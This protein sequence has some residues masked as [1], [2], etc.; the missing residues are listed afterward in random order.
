MENVRV[1]FAPSPTGFLH[2]GGARTALFNWLFAKHEGGKFILRIEDT[3]TERSTSEYKMNILEDLRWLGLDWDEGPEVEGRF[4]PYLQSQRFSIYQSYIQRLLDSGQAYY[5]FCSMQELEKERFESEKKK[6]PYHYSKKCRTLSQ[7]E[8]E[9]QMKNNVAFSIRIKVPNEGQLVIQDMIRGTVSFQ[10]NDFDDFIVVRSQG[11]ATYNLV[12][13]I[14]DALMKI[15]HVIRG[16]DHLSNTPKQILLY[17]ALSFEVPRFAHIPLILGADKS[18]LSKRHGAVSIGEFRRQGYLP[19][20]MI[21]YLAH[22]GWSMDGTTEVFS[23][24][25]L[26]KHFSLTRVIKSAACF[27][28]AKLQWLNGK[29]I[30]EMDKDT[31]IHLGTAVLLEKNIISSEFIKNHENQVRKIMLIV[32]D[33]VKLISDIAHQT[34]YFF[35]PIE[36]YNLELIEKFSNIEVTKRLE[37]F[38]DLILPMTSFDA[39]ELEKS[40]RHLA[41]QKKLKLADYVHPVRFALT[42]QLTS[43]GLFEVMEILGHDSCIDRITRLSNGL[44]TQMSAKK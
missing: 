14:D 15:S 33:H 28:Y 36:N 5:C 2:I 35:N 18:R 20:T 4:S 24:E 19:E 6:L 13:V 3:D 38:F 31:F 43:P 16:E 34:D 9:H 44:K 40:I 17:Q 22:L 23:R 27:D 26:V 12:V 8:I 42:G 37:E 1:R 32:K 25:T 30:R 41:D 29:Y 7:Q 11:G 39:V 21:N 10:W